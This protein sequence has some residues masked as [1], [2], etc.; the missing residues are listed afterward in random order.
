VIRKT[1]Y[2][3]KSVYDALRKIARRK[4]TSVSALGREAI[5]NI[6]R[7]YRNRIS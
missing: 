7:K 4:K 1:V 3:D 6:L 2:L 5:A